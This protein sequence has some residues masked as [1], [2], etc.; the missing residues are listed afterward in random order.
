[1]NLS[2]NNFVRDRPQ[3]SSNS[4][5]NAD[6]SQGGTFAEDKPSQSLLYWDGDNIT[7]SPLGT[8]FVTFGELFGAEPFGGFR[9]FLGRSDPPQINR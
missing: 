2:T 1:M 8:D 4:F 9:H 6:P 7:G 3:E 5:A